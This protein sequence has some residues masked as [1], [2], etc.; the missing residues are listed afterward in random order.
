M[1]N[2]AQSD[3]AELDAL[4]TR[5]WLESLDYVMQHGGP[6]RVGHLL[7]ELGRHAQ[8]SGVKLPFTANT[9]YI[10]TIHADEQAPYPGSRE[11]ERRIKSLVRWNAMAMVVRANR[12]EDGI[13][14]HISTYASAAT[15]YE[16]AF[17]HFFRG[18][19]GH[20]GDFVYLP[21]PRL[22]RHLRARLPRRAAVARAAAELPAR[23]GARGWLVELS[24][25]VADARLLGSAHGVDGARA[26]HGD[27][28]GPVQPLPG[29]PRPQARDRR[30]GLGVSRRRRDRRTRVARCHHA[31]V[32]RE[33]RQPD[34][35]RQ[36][37]PAAARRSGARQRSDHPGTRSHLPR[38][39][40]E[41]HQGHLGIGVGPAAG[42]RPPGPAH[43]T[44]G[45]DRRRS[46]TRSTRSKAAPTC[47]S[48]SGAPIPSCSRW[49]STSRTSSSRS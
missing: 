25:P 13:G 44:H 41:R 14:G 48:T 36:L 46:S 5:E 31:G 40:L 23:A 32:A 6:A 9:P 17:N 33:A 7:G 11:I 10:N 2:T 29:R 15:L 16:V 19:D 8:A 38:R 26:D 4:E 24:A 27:L 49:S 42:Q 21:G 3:A 35:R 12:E 37:Q 30:Q 34:L 47:A 22:A 39:R 20:E 28:P 45:R 43:E 18:R 1:R